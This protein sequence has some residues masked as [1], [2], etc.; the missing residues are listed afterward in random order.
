LKRFI[1]IVD[2]AKKVNSNEYVILTTSFDQ[3]LLG[4]FPSFRNIS[5]Y[6][7]FVWMHYYVTRDNLL[8]SSDSLNR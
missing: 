6:D 2:E 5:I 1:E 7:E 3:I 4:E 8:F